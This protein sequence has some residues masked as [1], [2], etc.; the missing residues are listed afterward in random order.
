MATGG[1]MFPLRRPSKLSWV[2]E[3]C[4]QSRVRFAAPNSG[5]PLTAARRSGQGGHRD[6]R[7]RR[8]HDAV[9]WERKTQKPKTPASKKD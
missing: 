1:I 7:L 2:P 4:S 8:E 9:F 6:G 5:A 3:R